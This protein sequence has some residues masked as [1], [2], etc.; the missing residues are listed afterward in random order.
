MAVV[1]VQSFLDA[2]GPR[3][4]D[5]II[6]NRAR[7]IDAYTPLVS[8]APKDGVA[9]ERDVAY[10]AHPRQR[11][12]VF[13]P[14]AA[15]DADVVLFVHGGA[16]VRGTKSVNGHF[17]DNVTYWFARHGVL[18]LNVEYRLAT[19]APYPSGAEDVAA[20][21]DWTIQNCRSHGGNPARI[22]LMG[23]S[24]GATHVATYALV[25]PFGT[26]RREQV[27]GLVLVSGRLR[28]DALPDNPNAD[29]VRTYYGPDSNCYDERSPVSYAE[30]CDIPVFL[31]IAEYENPYLDVYGAEFFYRIA[32]ARGRA[33]RFLRM[34]RHNH[35]SMVAHF[36]TG[37]ETLGREILDFFAAGR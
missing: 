19:D 35:A 36:N 20:A 15:S 18:A 17:F 6:G 29:A 4:R 5:D 34:P 37:E 9:V 25:P 21:V 1:N 3:W 23:H 22:F 28:V 12:D 13:R 33:P 14:E 11:I 16:F 8:L 32:R 31:A 24:A 7:V 10:G 30:S 2:I 26:R 27:C